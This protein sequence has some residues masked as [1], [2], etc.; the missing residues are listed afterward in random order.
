MIVVVKMM[1]VKT[2]LA[3]E[4]AMVGLQP[5]AWKQRK[6]G[7]HGFPCDDHVRE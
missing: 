2:V 7:S 5:N 4:S 6:S 1:S 3:K